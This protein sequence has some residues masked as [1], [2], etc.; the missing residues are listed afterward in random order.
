MPKIPHSAYSQLAFLASLLLIDG[1]MHQAHSMNQPQSDRQA[2]DAEIKTAVAR[3]LA[4]SADNMRLDDPSVI[5]VEM[6][7][8]RNDIKIAQEIIKQ[9]SALP[10]NPALEGYPP[11]CAVL[12]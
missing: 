4:V 5:K 6:L 3:F 10:R 9:G 2:S 7:C 11:W 12:S 1:C 8:G